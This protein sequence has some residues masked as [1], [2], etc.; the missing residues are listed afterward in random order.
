MKI[1]SS[2][3]TKFNSWRA[4]K[5]IAQIEQ[6]QLPKLYFHV[7]FFMF[8]FQARKDSNLL[9]ALK[10][11]DNGT[12]YALRSLCEWFISFRF[13]VKQYDHYKDVCLFY[14]WRN[15][16]KKTT[17]RCT[18]AVSITTLILI[19]I[20]SSLHYFGWLNFVFYFVSVEIVLCCCNNNKKLRL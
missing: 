18:K 6:K 8:E 1:Y 14:I 9:N 3:R 20:R 10:H 4:L 7:F 15:Q 5:Q 16:K 2:V 19:F 11:T 17:S 12:T 13:G